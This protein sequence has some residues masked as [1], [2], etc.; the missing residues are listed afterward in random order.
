MATKELTRTKDD[1]RAPATPARQSVLAFDP[2]SFLQSEI[3]RVF[4]SFNGDIRRRSGA[5]RGFWPSLE[6]KEDDSTIDISA[7][8]PGMEEKDVE[9][10]VSDNR[11]TIRGEKK[12][13]RDE[14]SKNYRLVER[15]YGS[16]ER[17]VDL[18]AG[19]DPSRVKASMKS[20]VL[21]VAIP[22]PAGS[23]A[24]KIPISKD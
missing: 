4:D 17:S 24:K 18:P 13:E 19:V 8:L 10:T 2:F 22:K 14:K 23:R 1:E 21:H 9:V 3:D 6:V 5:V 20:G 16:F 7:E 15:S 11:L 12:T